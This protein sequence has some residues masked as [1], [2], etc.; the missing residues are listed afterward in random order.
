MLTGKSVLRVNLPLVGTIY[1]QINKF[2]RGVTTKA[3]GIS[4]LNDSPGCTY[5]AVVVLEYYNLDSPPSQAINS[6]VN[7]VITKGDILWDI[8]NSE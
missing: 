7:S 3:R 6:R 2:V 5:T 4:K 1:P 8:Y